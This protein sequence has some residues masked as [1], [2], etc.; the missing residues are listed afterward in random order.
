M[1]V[2]LA[3]HT[4][5]MRDSGIVT[6]VVLACATPVLHER[7][8]KC[9]NTDCMSDSGFATKAILPACA[10]HVHCERFGKS[11]NTDPTASNS[12]GFTA[13][14]VL[15]H[16]CQNP[17]LCDSNLASISLVTRLHHTNRIS[18]SVF[19]TEAVPASATPVL[20][21]RFGKSDLC[22]RIGN[23][24]TICKG[25]VSSAMCSNSFFA[26]EVVPGCATPVLRERIGTSNLCDRIGNERTNCKGIVSSVMHSDSLFA[27]EAVPAYATPVFHMRLVKS[28]L[29]DRIGNDSTICEGSV[30]SVTRP[31][32]IVDK[33]GILP[34][35]LS[36]PHT[37]LFGDW[38]DNEQL[39]SIHREALLVTNKDHHSDVEIFSKF[40]LDMDHDSCKEMITKLLSNRVIRQCV[41][42]VLIETGL[43]QC[44]APILSQAKFKQVP[45]SWLDCIQPYPVD[46][47]A[48]HTHHQGKNSGKQRTGHSNSYKT[49][50]RRA[51]KRA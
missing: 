31:G 10:T 40:L 7:F 12:T 36:Y 29:C 41:Q 11:N 35:S 13:E 33:R 17:V 27:P 2:N 37:E 19:A 46:E 6:N 28:D 16:E 34:S 18:N 15:V 26:T 51:L 5:R 47:L 1:S 23:E 14:V 42:E 21:E 9:D 38:C 30:S 43:S 45:V 24:I 22:D 4:N 25:S 49:S 32:N 39:S 3:N 50:A 20:R 8:E 44:A 48:F